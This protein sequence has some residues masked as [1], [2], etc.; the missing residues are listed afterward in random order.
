MTSV[1]GDQVVGFGHPM[2]L[3]GA[4][5]LGL[6]P[7]DAIY[8]QQDLV[9]GFKV[10]NL[11]APVG[12][13][14]D[15]R[16]TGITGTF[17]AL[18]RTTDVSSTATFGSRTRTVDSHVVLDN[19]DALASTVLYSVI[20]NHQMVVD[21]PV[22]GTENLAWTITGSDADGTPFELQSDDLFSGKDVTYD[23]GFAVAD[24]VYEIARIPGVSIDSVT[25]DGTLTDGVKRKKVSKV[26]IREHGVWT[27]VGGR[28]PIVAKAGARLH[29]RL[30]LTGSG[31]TSVAPADARR[32]G[33]VRGPHRDPPGRRRGAGR[34]GPASQGRHRPRGLA[35]RAAPQR[36]GAGRPLDRTTR[37]HQW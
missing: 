17:G 35:G 9:A 6:H 19:P 2:D 29:L 21:G 22:Q 1:C 30:T 26:E 14:T 20:A 33:P 23:L 4:T 25:S 3:F 18:P 37:R 12:T 5:T 28:S 11:G 10:A 13:I 32:A 16:L 24:L 36:R 15:D 27:K 34:H 31:G 8:I 7:A